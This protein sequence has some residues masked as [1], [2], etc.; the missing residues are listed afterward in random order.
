M[1]ITYR[2][3]YLAMFYLNS[4]LNESN[5]EVFWAYYKKGGEPRPQTPII[6]GI[7]KYF[8][9]IKRGNGSV[10]DSVEKK[11]IS[12]KETV[13]SLIIKKLSI[14]HARLEEDYIPELALFIAF[15]ATK[16]PRAIESV[17]ELGETLSALVEKLSKKPDEIK[18]S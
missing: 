11:L 5:D 15:M 10:D 16:I 13:V 18:E 17:R 3:H 6:T 12:P 4:L 2:T 9:N 1:N 8:Y 7:E 14:S